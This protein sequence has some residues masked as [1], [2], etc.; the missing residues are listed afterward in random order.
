MSDEEIGETEQEALQL[1]VDEQESESPD[2]T[3]EPEGPV[4]EALSVEDLVESLETVIAER[5]DFRD[6]LQRLQADF[7]NFRRRSANEVDQRISQ[8]ISR[9][10]E[11]LLP[12]LDACDAAS[13]QG[14]EEVAPIRNALEAV[15]ANN[16]LTRIEALGV[17]FDP[18]LHDAMSFETGESDDQI[19]VEELRA[20]YRWGESILRPSMVKVSGG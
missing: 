20:G 12:V 1:E 11:A 15:L 10:A 4:A 6:S 14:L 2:T 16:G 5:D 8:G 18:Q 17:Q 13:E 3:E 9:L 7:E 19:V